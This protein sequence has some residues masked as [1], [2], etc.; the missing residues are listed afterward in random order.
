MA[1]SEMDTSVAE[2]EGEVPAET[3][4]KPWTIHGWRP[5]SAVIHPSSVARIGAGMAATASHSHQRCF[6]RER[7]HRKKTPITMSR[8]ISAPSPT[9]MWKLMNVSATGGQ[10][11]GSTWSS[12]LITPFG[13]R[14]DIALRPYGIA[15]PG[16]VPPTHPWL[17]GTA[18]RS[19]GTLVAVVQTPS[20]AANLTGWLA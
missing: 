15:I 18:I 11:D 1:T 6:S 8:S 12:P 7:R 3:I 17:G 2:T 10:S 20:I 5:T 9:I 14:S 4:I 19:S 16:P 13:S